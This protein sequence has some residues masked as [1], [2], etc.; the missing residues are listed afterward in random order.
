[1]NDSRLARE[2]AT[3]LDSGEI[4]LLFQPQVDLATGRTVA[5]EALCRWLHPELGILLPYAFIPVAEEG[6]LIGRV[7]ELVIA[8]GL[9]AA[10]D[11]RDAGHEI[12]I[13]INVSPSQ[14]TIP[15]FGAALSE[16]VR[17]SGLDPASITLEITETFPIEDVVGAT[18]NLDPLR[19]EGMVIAIDDYGAGYSSLSRLDDLGAGELKIDRS[20]LQSESPAT[21]GHLSDVVAYA[22][23]RSIR[24]VA[25]GVERPA[26][27]DRARE[28]ACDRAQGFL[29]GSPMSQR[30]ISKRLTAELT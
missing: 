28:L 23:D 26:H 27:L 7:G 19:A 15:T 9:A 3:A 12:G 13:A 6:G 5:V 14:L 16:A 29:L 22:H 1:M 18:A 17:A 30:E 2:L 21:A 10:S 4:I 8:E 11:W 20:L 24:V 25:E